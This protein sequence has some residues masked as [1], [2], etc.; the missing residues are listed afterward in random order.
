MTTI[1]EPALYDG[2]VYPFMLCLAFGVCSIY[3]RICQDI[4]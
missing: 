4:I 2:A 3:K 1:N